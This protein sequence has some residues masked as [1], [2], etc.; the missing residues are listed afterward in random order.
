[1][2]GGF[3]LAD[4]QFR[5]D[6]MESRMDRLDEQREREDESETDRGLQEPRNPMHSERELSELI[7]QSPELRPSEPSHEPLVEWL[8]L[9]LLI[10]IPLLIVAVNWALDRRTTAQR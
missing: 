3:L 4:A 7:E 10:L 8:G 1:M 6:D 9:S 2:S 5:M